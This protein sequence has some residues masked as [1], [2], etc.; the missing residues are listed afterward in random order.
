MMRGIGRLVRTAAVAAALGL[1]AQG[2][3]MAAESSLMA[4][5]KIASIDAQRDL[6]KLKT[7]L[8]ST[9]EFMIK[10]HTK[11]SDGRQPVEL[12][13]LRPGIEATV[14]Y[15]QEDG[16]HVAKSIT[17]GSAGAESGASPQ[18]ERAQPQTSPAP[19]PSSSPAAP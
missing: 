7:G 14:E 10:P 15:V 12:E 5:G 19:S 9:Q 1:T 16:K 6:V 13:A 17:V 4:F 11:I 3:V 8:F 2:M 18:A